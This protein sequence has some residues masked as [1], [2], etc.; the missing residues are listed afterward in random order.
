MP[1]AML[2]EEWWWY[3]SQMGTG[4]LTPRGA[5]RSP[6]PGSQAGALRAGKL[7]TLPAGKRPT[8]PKQPH[9]V[10]FCIDRTSRSRRPRGKKNTARGRPA[11]DHRQ[12]PDPW[13]W[14]WARRARCRQ[15]AAEPSL[16]LCRSAAAFRVHDLKFHQFEGARETSSA[17]PVHR[18]HAAPSPR[19]CQ[20]RAAHHDGAR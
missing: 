12:W 1:S 10:E 15:L 16:A 3:F 7:A 4:G 13:P 2:S 17:R 11:R 14:P 8:T 5:G 20:L 18:T 9:L 6:A 19:G